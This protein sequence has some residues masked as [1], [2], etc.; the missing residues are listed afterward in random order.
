MVM[1][2]VLPYIYN[3]DAG[4][5]GAKTR[6]LYAELCAVTATTT[7]FL[8]PEMKGRTT[9]EIQ[10]AEESFQGPAVFQHQQKS[11]SASQM[12]FYLV[13][14]FMYKDIS[15]KSLISVL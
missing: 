12:F 1:D 14:G 9:M 5:L 15:G 3:T 6:F 11:A 8:M 13:R 2:L 10:V 7:W 4:D